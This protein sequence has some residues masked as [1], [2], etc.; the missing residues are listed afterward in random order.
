MGQAG[1]E[2]RIRNTKDQNIEPAVSVTRSLPSR[3]QTLSGPVSG[4]PVSTFSQQSLLII[5]E[6]LGH[7]QNKLY[8]LKRHSV[9]DARGRLLST[10]EA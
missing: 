4:P 8:L 5:G 10:K 2:D 6:G 7:C 9:M 3:A 1:L